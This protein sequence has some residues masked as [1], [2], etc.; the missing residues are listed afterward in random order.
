MP[1]H[2]KLSDPGPQFIGVD[3]N[4]VLSMSSGKITLRQPGALRVLASD[5]YSPAIFR[6]IS[7]SGCLSMESPESRAMTHTPGQGT[8]GTCVYGRS[9]GASGFSPLVHL[10]SPTAMLCAGSGPFPS[11]SGELWKCPMKSLRW[12]QNTTW[13][14]ASPFFS[15]VNSLESRPQP[16]KLRSFPLRANLIGRSKQNRAQNQ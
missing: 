12:A 9:K 3:G 11:P 14:S 6:A 7:S 13:L 8:K 16:V 1:F 2:P 15:L 4:N 5:F 10:A